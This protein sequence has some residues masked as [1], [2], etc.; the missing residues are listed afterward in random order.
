MSGENYYSN[1]I[2]SQREKRAERRRQANVLPSASSSSD[3]DDFDGDG[4]NLEA[5]TSYENNL[6]TTTFNAM[7]LM[8]YMPDDDENNE[9]MNIPD[10]SAPLFVSSRHTV[11]SATTSIM[12]F[13]MDANLDKQ[14]TTKLLKLVKSL[15]PQPNSLPTTHRKLLKVFGVTSL[16]STKY[17]CER[18]GSD[19][20]T[21]RCGSKRCTNS[22][23]LFSSQALVNSRVT[24][25]VSMD[26]RSA[27]HEIV[28]RNQ[29]LIFANEM[30]TPMGD[31][32]NYSNYVKNS[33]ENKVRQK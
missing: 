6:N 20:V 32:V 17:L 8:D 24:E 15:L 14:Q 28:R 27:L 1:R 26:I 10:N 30:L 19:T 13:A 31:I 16:F 7:N 9:G 18:C 5:S 25:I 22:N 33:K 2:I 11:V 3:S 23:C 21:I 12:R 29:K 4:T